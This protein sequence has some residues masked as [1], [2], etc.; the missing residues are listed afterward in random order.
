MH[1][2]R[3][4]SLP[5]DISLLYLLL[6]ECLGTV[7]YSNFN[8]S[9]NSGVYLGVP[10]T[11]N[12]IYVSGVRYNSLQFVFIYLCINRPSQLACCQK[13]PLHNGML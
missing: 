9:Q 12:L 2:S 8:F 6:Q 10:D 4:N 7:F 3:A 13:D 1:R 11:V 5:S